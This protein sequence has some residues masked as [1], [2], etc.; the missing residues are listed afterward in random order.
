MDQKTRWQVDIDGATWLAKHNAFDYPNPDL[1]LGNPVVLTA[2]QV[3]EVK[4]ENL[5]PY[6]D[7]AV[8]ESFIYGS[9]EDA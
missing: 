5:T 8:I 3:L 4:V 7:D 2:G 6:G 1:F 9:E